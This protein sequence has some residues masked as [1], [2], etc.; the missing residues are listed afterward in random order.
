M[1]PPGHY[2]QSTN[3]FMATHPHGHNMMYTSKLLILSNQR[4]L[5]DSKKEHNKTVY[6]R[7]ATEDFEIKIKALGGWK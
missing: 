1:Y 3:V 2:S 4:V 7:T 5:N 6:S